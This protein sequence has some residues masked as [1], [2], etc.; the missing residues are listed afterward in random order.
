MVDPRLSSSSTS[1]INNNLPATM[2][3][4]DYS[5]LAKTLN[6]NVPIKLDKSNYIY[7]KTQVMPAIRALDLEDYISGSAVIP[8]PYI[9][10]PAA[11]NYVQSNVQGSNINQQTAA[12]YATPDSVNDQ[13]WYVHSGATNHVTADMNNLS[14]KSE[15]RELFSTSAACS[16]P[17]RQCS[18]SVSTLFDMFQSSKSIRPAPSQ[19]YISTSQGMLYS[20][21]ATSSAPAPPVPVPSAV[22]EVSHSAD[23]P[24]PV[25]SAV[26]PTLAV[27]SSVAAPCSSVHPMQTRLK[28]GFNGST[29]RFCGFQSAYSCIEAVIDQVSYDQTIYTNCKEECR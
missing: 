29:G 21:A 11:S 28:N 23:P 22:A 2:N 15:Y 10:I 9:D 16:L 13:A 27:T 7:W 12:Y 14:L 18:N 4:I 5:S 1:Q 20:S 24:I 26:A 17:D 19:P 25:S 6:S 3:Q 8:E